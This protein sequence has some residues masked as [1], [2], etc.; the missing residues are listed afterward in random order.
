MTTTVKRPGAELELGTGTA[1]LALADVEPGQSLPP[2]AGLLEDVLVG[3]RTLFTTPT[4]LR[5]AW[6]AFAPLLGDDRPAPEPYAVGSWGPAS[7]ARLAEPHGWA[8]GD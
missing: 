7:A 2:Y 8:L 3:D 5:A 6:I 4:G 1:D